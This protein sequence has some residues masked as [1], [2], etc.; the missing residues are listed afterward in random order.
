VSGVEL[1]GIGGA[2]LTAGGSLYLYMKRRMDKFQ[3]NH[4]KH[5][6]DDLATL[7]ND[8]KDLTSEVKETFGFLKGLEIDK[9][10]AQHD[11]RIGSLERSNTGDGPYRARRKHSR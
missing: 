7:S 2:I 11:E 10:L 9:R 1:S 6:G 5:I 8:V 3:D 4:L